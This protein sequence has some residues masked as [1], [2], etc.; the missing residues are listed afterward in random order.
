MQ[1]KL[2]IAQGGMDDPNWIWRVH[3][4]FEKLAPSPFAQKGG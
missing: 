3:P 4:T 1:A 2:S